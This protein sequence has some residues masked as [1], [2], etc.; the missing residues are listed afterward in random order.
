MTRNEYIRLLCTHIQMEQ[1][2]HNIVL[3]KI[4]SLLFVTFKY[5]GILLLECDLVKYSQSDSPFNVGSVV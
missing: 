1:M 4:A 3:F 2:I 5:N